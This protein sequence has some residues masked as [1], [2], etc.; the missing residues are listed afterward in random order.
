MGEYKFNTEIYQV[1]GKNIKKFRVKENLKLEELSLKTN[2]STKKLKL[3]EDDSNYK[4]SIND[5]YKISKALNVNIK[6]FFPKQ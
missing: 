4:I 6:E 5:L 1:V 2:I 3:I